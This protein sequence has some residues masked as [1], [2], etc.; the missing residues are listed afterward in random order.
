MFCVNYFNDLKIFIFIL[1]V[2]VG[3]W[4]VNLR[5][6]ERIKMIECFDFCVLWFIILIYVWVLNILFIFRI[7]FNVMRVSNCKDNW[8]VCLC[9]IC[10]Y[11]FSVGNWLCVCMSLCYI[12]L[13]WVLVLNFINCLIIVF[14]FFF[15]YIILWKV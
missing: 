1:I 8:I 15:F 11:K 9:V 5:V 13:Y 12:Y 4:V 3:L 2:V 10:V 7:F 6:N 14:K